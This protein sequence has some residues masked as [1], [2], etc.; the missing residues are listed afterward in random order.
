ME[1]TSGVEGTDVELWSLV[2]LWRED[3]CGFKG[4]SDA[5][6]DVM[7]IFELSMLEIAADLELASQQNK[8]KFAV[9][10]FNH[11]SNEFVG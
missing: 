3:N 8:V 1:K 9:S 10:K 5:N 2:V 7:K 11:R 6:L 4:K